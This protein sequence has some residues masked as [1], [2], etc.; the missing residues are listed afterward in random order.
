MKTKRE[1][2]FVQKALFSPISKSDFDIG[3]GALVDL[4]LVTEALAEFLKL[5]YIKDSTCLSG[6]VLRLFQ[7][8]KVDFINREFQE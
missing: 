6:N 2:V 3:K 7:L 5:E 4:E 8:R 1:F